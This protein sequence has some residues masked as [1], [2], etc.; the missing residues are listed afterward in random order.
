VAIL[1]ETHNLEN[2]SLT[3]MKVKAS[4]AVC[5]EL[6]EIVRRRNDAE[7]CV[8]LANRE[9]RAFDSVKHALHLEDWGFAWVQMNRLCP[10]GNDKL[11]QV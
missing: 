2:R 1:A 10:L 9:W 6:G 11:H 3:K 4:D 5:P 7:K 8:R